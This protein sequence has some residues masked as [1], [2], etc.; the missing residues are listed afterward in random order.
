MKGKFVPDNVMKACVGLRGKTP[1]VFKPG[2]RWICMI[3]FS[4]SPLYPSEG[5]A[6][7]TRLGGLQS[8]SE[9]LQE[10]KV[11]GPWW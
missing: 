11:Y 4:L 1:Y 6:G 2:T 3:S 8:S 7:N 10:G 9:L 5:T